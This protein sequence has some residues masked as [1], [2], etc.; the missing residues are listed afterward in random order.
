MTFPD[1]GAV[2][3]NIEGELD[4]DVLTGRGTRTRRCLRG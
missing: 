2:M 3:P 4:F 1:T